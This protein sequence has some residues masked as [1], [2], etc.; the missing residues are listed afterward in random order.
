MSLDLDAI[1]AR[2]EAAID[3]P[4]IA[5]DVYVTT[6]S[7]DLLSDAP[8]AAATAVFIAHAREDVPALVA[9]VER[10]RQHAHM[11]RQL[12]QQSTLTQSPYCA[13][14]GDAWPCMTIRLLDGEP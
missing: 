8:D 5:D 10:L 14:C 12:H 13:G 4:W 6:E 11:V 1:K 9:E 3:G 7:G 2:A